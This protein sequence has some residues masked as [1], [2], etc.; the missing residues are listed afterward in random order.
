MKTCG[1]TTSNWI[2]SSGRRSVGTPASPGPSSLP[3]ASPNLHLNLR[4]GIGLTRILRPVP[5]NEHLVSNAAI[6]LL[7]RLLRYEHTDRPTAREAMAHE[8]F[9]AVRA[10]EKVRLREEEKARR[11]AGE[12]LSWI[13]SEA[14]RARPAGLTEC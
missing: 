4:A 8:Y 12:A 13:R 7:D 6:D 9:E 5:D 10:A 11:A 2:P 3:R 1:S 14:A